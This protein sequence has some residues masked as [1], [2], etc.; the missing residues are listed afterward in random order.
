MLIFLKLLLSL[1]FVGKNSGDEKRENVLTLKSGA[2]RKGKTRA[3]AAQLRA[4]KDITEMDPVPG[5]V[6]HFP[7]PNNLMD[8]TV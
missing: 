2:G 3:T 1:L 7:D 6:L 8:F 4:Q 5:C